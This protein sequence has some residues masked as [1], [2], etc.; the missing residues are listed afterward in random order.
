M[1][2][3]IA[4]TE[5]YL[6]IEKTRFADRLTVETQVAEYRQCRVWSPP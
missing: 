3:E 6:D 4:T 2:E 5:L 1:A